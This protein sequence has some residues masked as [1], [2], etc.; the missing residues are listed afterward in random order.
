MRDRAMRSLMQIAC[1]LG[2]PGFLAA[3]MRAPIPTG[4]TL[5]QGDYTRNVRCTSKVAGGAHPAGLLP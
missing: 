3:I 5:L 2:K 4:L 1:L